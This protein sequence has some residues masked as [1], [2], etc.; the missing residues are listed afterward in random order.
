MKTENTLSPTIDAERACGMGR[1]DVVRP[2]GRTALPLAAVRI[3]ARVADRVAQVCVEQ[4]FRNPF[5]EALEAVYI[6]PLSGSAAVNAFTLK[7]GERT[8]KGLVKE[9][10]EAR[11]AYDAALKQGNRA[12]LLEQERDDVFTVSVGNLPPGAEAAVRLEYSERLP[13]F[14]DGTTEL[15]LPLVVAP[16]YIPGRELPRDP[17]GDGT[18]WDTDQVPDASRITPPRLVK[19]FDPRVALAVEVRLEGGAVEDLACSQHALRLAGG[20]IALARQ[21]ELQNR[22]FVLRWRLAG[23]ALKTTLLRTKDGY[24][25]L[26]ILPPRREG[27]LGLAR[28]VV[29]LLD[30]SGSMGG[31]KMASA[32]RACA[33]L[34]QTLGPRDRFAIGAFDNGVE[35]LGGGKLTCADE[36]GLTAGDKFLR[37]IAARGGTELDPAMAAALSLLGGRGEES[38][39]APIIV[40]VTDGQVGNEA[41]VFARIQKTGGDC[42]VFTVGIDTA[43]NAAFLE[44]LAALGGG[45][46]VLAV[47]GE[48][49]EDA[50]RGIAREI[51]APLVVDLTIEGVDEPAPAR[52][53]DL[54]AGRAVTMFFRLKAGRTVR[55]A[56]R[57]GDGKAFKASVKPRAL[58]LP[59]VGSLWARGRVADLED[60]LRLGGDAAALK[61]EIVALAV[62]HALLT[63]FTSFVA[64]DEAEAVNPGGEAR[65]VVQPVHLP[66][67]WEEVQAVAMGFAASAGIAAQPPAAPPT[68]SVPPLAKGGRGSFSLSTMGLAAG[69]GV[70]WGG[71]RDARSEPEEVSPAQEAAFKEAVEELRRALAGV[72]AQLGRGSRPEAAALDKAR[73]AMLKELAGSPLG[74]KLAA[75]QRAL[76][77][78]PLEL[79]AALEAKGPAAA[80]P[81]LLDKAEREFEEALRLGGARS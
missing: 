20:T 54:F 70:G 47:P 42:R 62:R 3:G 33:L 61:K 13:Y 14:E 27:F 46:C 66:E 35:W 45:T 5:T 16:R 69:P 15:R 28:D 7:V 50:L 34:L 18:Q 23:A 57:Y 41:A 19:G 43:V 44:R 37:G 79:V 9:R 53:P 75:L 25:M 72:R 55:I 4:T 59:A 81:A 78:V 12:A 58:D 63:R 56:G 68:A 21:D 26:S 24:G 6:F 10:G 1:L 48:A 39:R 36:A 38:G 67:Q 11:R 76:R 31:T 51:G 2:E 30:R 60:R 29:F 71:A 32:A 22:D 74:V 77:T 52:A 73:R 64:V 17:A 40:V 8:I 49:L 80:V 65:T